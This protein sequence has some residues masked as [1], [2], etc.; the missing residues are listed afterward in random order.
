MRTVEFCSIPFYRLPYCALT[1]ILRMSYLFIIFLS[2]KDVAKRRLP[3]ASKR[4]CI[5]Q[6]GFF[7][8]GLYSDP[9]PEGIARGF[10]DCSCRFG[11]CS[12]VLVKSG[13]NSTRA[14]QRCNRSKSPL[15]KNPNKAGARQ[16]FHNRSL[17]FLLTIPS[18]FWKELPIRGVWGMSST[19]AT[20]KNC[21]EQD[22]SA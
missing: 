18:R 21:M 2:E 20:R 6:A 16:Y 7:I 22:V 17:V 3:S 1:Y 19:S 15:V 11:D 13:E 10:G 12:N 9:Y 14:I 5:V 8:Q 4:W